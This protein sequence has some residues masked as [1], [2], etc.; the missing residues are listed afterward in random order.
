MALGASPNL[1]HA[2][3]TW[4][5]I[6]DPDVS[7]QSAL[8]LFTGLRDNR[9]TRRFLA[10]QFKADYALLDTKFEGNYSFQDIVEVRAVRF[11][12]MWAHLT[13]ISS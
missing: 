11:L 7:G 12:I 9:K 10:E 2:A 6:L 13:W 1:D 8:Y 3:E 4:K 5:V